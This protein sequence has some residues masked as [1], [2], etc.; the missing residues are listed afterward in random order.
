M[1]SLIEEPKIIEAF[2]AQFNEDWSKA[3]EVKL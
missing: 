2:R 3:T 1:F